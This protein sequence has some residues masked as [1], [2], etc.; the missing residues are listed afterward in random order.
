MAETLDP[1][2]QGMLCLNSVHTP[3]NRVDL[4]KQTDTSTRGNWCHRD[5]VRGLTSLRFLLSIQQDSAQAEAT[6]TEMGEGSIGSLW[7]RFESVT[8]GKSYFERETTQ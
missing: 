8:I 2:W 3:Y 5:K 7:T 1:W 6:P 4:H